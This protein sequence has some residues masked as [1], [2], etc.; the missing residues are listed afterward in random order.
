MIIAHLR[1]DI[2]KK[3]HEFVIVEANGVG[4]R[5]GISRLTAEQLPEVKETVSLHIYHHITEVSQALFGFLSENDQHIFEL[6]I[7][8][9][10]VGPRLALAMMSGMNG[11]ELIENILR[12]DI[13]ALSRI[14]GIGKKTAER[15]ALELQDRLEHQRKELVLPPNLPHSDLASEAVAAL[16]ALGYKRPLIE[17]IVYGIIRSDVKTNTVSDIIKIALR[18]LQ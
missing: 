9:K 17:N 4:Y 2:L 12:K 10:S 16:I 11:L 5:V 8:V 6:L 1:G 15:I 7:T 14:P 3:S 18:Q 13:T